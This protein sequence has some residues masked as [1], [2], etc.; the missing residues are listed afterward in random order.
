[1]HGKPE[2]P[3]SYGMVAEFESADELLTAARR[4]REAGYTR[5]DAFSPFPIHG[6]SE[7]LDFHDNRVPWI[8][9]I[10]GVLGAGAGLALQSYV[11]A[12]DYPLNVGGKPLLSWPAFL[13]VTFECTILFASLSAFLSVLVLNR[14]P[15]PYHPVFNTPNFARASQDRFFLAIEARDGQYDSAETKRFMETLEAVA[16]SEVGSDPGSQEEDF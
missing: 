16:V 4:T 2:P 13:P 12:I 8:V 7:A 6:L 11:S 9:F 10:A 3:K 14:L 15:L 5:I 1:M